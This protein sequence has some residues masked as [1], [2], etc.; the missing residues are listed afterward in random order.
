MGGV[1]IWAEEAAEAFRVQ[2]KIYAPEVQKWD[3]LDFIGYKQRNLQIAQASNLV[4]VFVVEKY[5]PRYKGMR[6]KG[7]YHCKGRISEHVK[8]GACWTAWKSGVGEW[9]IIK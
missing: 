7:C 5:P 6:F 2:T 3:G 8:S 1:D 9:R 4:L